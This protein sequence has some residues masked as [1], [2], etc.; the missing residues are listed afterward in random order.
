MQAYKKFEVKG[1]HQRF[2]FST[3]EKELFVTVTKEDLP[4]FGQ[5][6]FKQTRKEYLR[7]GLD[8]LLVDPDRQDGKMVR[9]QE[10]QN[11]EFLVPQRVL[12][13]R[14]ANGMVS[15]PDKPKRAIKYIKEEHDILICEDSAELDQ[16]FFPIR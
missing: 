2:V 15:V 7:L 10:A 6:W 16:D 4:W 5:T 11:S 9:Q 12:R 1:C 13:P 8:K 3:G 14:G